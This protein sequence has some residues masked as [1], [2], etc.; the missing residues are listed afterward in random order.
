[1]EPS[2]ESQLLIMMTLQ[3][4]C[5]VTNSS[6]W[7]EHTSL[8]SAYSVGDNS[9]VSTAYC[10]WGF[11]RDWLGLVETWRDS[12]RMKCFGGASKMAMV[13]SVYLFPTRLICMC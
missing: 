10:V 12:R 4:V 11:T 3:L 9:D 2:Q 13:L 8:F 5:W 6:S 7:D 1:M